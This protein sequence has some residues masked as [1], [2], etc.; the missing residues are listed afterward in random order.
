[1]KSLITSLLVPMTV[2]VT[3]LSASCSQPP[4]TCTVSTFT[5][6]AAKYALVEG[7]GSCAERTGDIIGMANYNPATT[8]S[9]GNTVPNLS[10]V[11]LAIRTETL[12]ALAATAKEMGVEDTTEGHVPHAFGP[13]D[14]ALPQNDICTATLGEARQDLE[15]IPQQPFDPDAGDNP[16]DPDDDFPGQDAVAMGEKW[17]QV[18]VFV[19][20]ANLGTQMKA[21]YTVTD[22]AEGCSATY[23]VLAVFPAVFC[24]DILP[25]GDPIDIVSI[26]DDSTDPERGVVV[27]TDGPHGLAVDDVVDI[28]DVDDE[29]GNVTFDGSYTVAEVIDDTTFV[30]N[31]LDPFGLD[32]EDDGDPE[33][34][35]TGNVQKFASV[36]NPDYCSPV[37]LPEKG[38]AVGSGISP[39][40]PVV[41]DPDLLMCVLDADP[42]AATFPIVR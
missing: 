14:S 28:A 35:A 37:A 16:E 34:T 8:D 38:L 4:V 27:V 22:D 32:D 12:G 29:E 39:D 2:T 25:E 36:A 19:N 20:A 26:D 40:F 33:V 42:S 41:C 21:R 13:F 7:T 3:V 17:E 9:Y 24:E 18:Q 31:E 30:T 23:D 15:E 11:S 1:M 5:G 10:S 6:Y